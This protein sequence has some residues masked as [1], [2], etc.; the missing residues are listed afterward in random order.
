MFDFASLQD[1]QSAV[2][3]LHNDI[4]AESVAHFS[5]D[6]RSHLGASIIGHDCAR[7]AWNVFR[8][9]GFEN[10]SG[11]MYRLF[12]R[13]HREE[14]A[15]IARLQ[16]VGFVIYEHDPATGKQFRITGAN[17]HFGGSADGIAY[18]PERYGYSLPII[19]EFK[20]HN[21]KSFTKLAGKIVT[22]TPEYVRK[23]GEGVK[24]SKP[25]HFRQMSV[26][27]RAYGIKYGIYC[28]VN[29]DT[30]EYYFEF[31]ELD[32]LEA[33]RR[34]TLAEQIVNSRVP[35]PKIA[36]SIA[37]FD[38]KYCFYGRNCHAGAMPAKN[39]RSCFNAFA[40]ENAEW[41]CQVHNSN[42]PKEVI[43]L[44]CDSWKSII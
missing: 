10:F 25:Q 20:T 18:L 17:G 26:Y 39:C 16:G 6:P 35:P 11:R 21:E 41:Y 7:Y 15:L 12:N 13:G 32:W 40:V 24:L 27:G 30:D 34:F 8:W 5:E 4:N 42:I 23:N 9:I 2:R 28:A 1:R 31:V 22:K 43:P 29:K 3:Q 37:F 38:C 44:G 33:D 14:P 19:A 36:E